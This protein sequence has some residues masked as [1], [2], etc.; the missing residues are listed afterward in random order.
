MHSARYFLAVLALCA[1][2]TI[3]LHGQT[4]DSVR[5]TT[6]GTVLGAKPVAQPGSAPVQ[7]SSQRS[8]RQ[9]GRRH[10]RTGSGLTSWAAFTDDTEFDHSHWEIW[11][12]SLRKL[13]ALLAALSLRPGSRAYGGAQPSGR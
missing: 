4:P 10:D 5:W 1:L 2:A 9:D 13:P 3:P 6:L 7:F 12:S 8:D 11:S